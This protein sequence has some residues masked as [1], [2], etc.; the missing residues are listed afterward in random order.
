[1]FPVL[2]QGDSGSPLQCYMP[3]LGQWAFAGVSSWGS[4]ACR[5]FPSVYMR[6]SSYVDW[7]IEHVPELETDGTGNTLPD[8]APDVYPEFIVDPYDM[9]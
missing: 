6:V 9:N 5:E 8:T 4:G 2:V 3:F 1:M 7:I